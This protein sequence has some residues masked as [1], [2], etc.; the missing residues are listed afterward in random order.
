MKKYKKPKYWVKA[1]K[2]LSSKDPI[3]KKIIKKYYKVVLF[4]RN[5]PFTTLTRSIIGQQ[6][7]VTVAD[8]IWIK[9]K[10]NVITEDITGLETINPHDLLLSKIYISKIGLSQKKYNHIIELARF[11]TLNPD[12]GKNFSNLPDDEIIKKL[13]KHNG[14][15]PWT[16]KMFLLFYLMRPNVFPESDIGLINS[17]K[18]IYKLKNDICTKKQVEKISKNWEPWKTVATWYLWCETD[19]DP[20][21][22]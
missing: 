2:E 4:S 8:K 11:F 5:D 12:Y 1:C 15:G 13:I 22:Y 6:V 16:A 3:L 7:S 21:V 20:I 14:I 17:I 10:E 19:P 9:L 18:K